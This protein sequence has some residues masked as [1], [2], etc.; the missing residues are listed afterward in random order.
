MEWE[1]VVSLQTTRLAN[2]RRLTKTGVYQNRKFLAGSQS[3]FI[4][5]GWQMADCSS[6]K[7]GWFA[8]ERWTISSH[9]I[10]NQIWM[11]FYE[12][13]YIQPCC[14]WPKP[15]VFHRKSDHLLLCYWQ[16]IKQF[17]TGSWSTSRHFC[18][19]QNRYFKP[20]HEIFLL[21]LILRRA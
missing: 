12:K 14:C 5:Q 11:F 9:V 16:K 17:F 8:M 21:C 3:I 7:T 1:E 10:A 18:G 13:T 6:T 20:N 2:R 4:L 15:G 19:G